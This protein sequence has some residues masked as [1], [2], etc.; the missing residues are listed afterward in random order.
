MADPFIGEIRLF[1]FGVVPS[2]WH[3]C[4]GTLLTI[5]Q[6]QAL[7][8]ILGTTYGG[9]TNVNFKLP[10]LRGRVPVHPAYGKQDVIND[11]LGGASG[12]ET[13]TLTLAETPQHTHIALAS[14]QNAT[15]GSPSGTVWATI[16]SSDTTTPYAPT[17]SA[18]GATPMQPMRADALANSGGNSPHNNMQPFLVGNYCIALQ[19]VFPPR[20]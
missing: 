7:Y 12:A 11:G 13:H 15:S 20:G 14:S 2:G 4:D 5:Q 6:Y 19:G 1:P 16:P 3:L 18:S 8:A 9:T 10:D 17:T